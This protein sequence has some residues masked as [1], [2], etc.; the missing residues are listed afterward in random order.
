MVNLNNIIK[1]NNVKGSV[2][3]YNLRDENTQLYNTVGSFTTDRYADFK[4]NIKSVY[5]SFANEYN[6]NI[7]DEISNIAKADNLREVYKNRLLGDVMESA[8]EDP[9]FATMP[10]K[11]EQLFE[12]TMFEIA[13]ESSAMMLYPAIGLTLPILKKNYIEGHSKDI[14]MTEVATKPVVRVAFERK[15]LKDKEGNKYY[16]PEIYYDNSYK[17]VL[18]KGQ[19]DP[20]YSDW[21]PELAGVLPMQDYDLLGKSGGSIE[22]RDRFDYNLAITAVQM[23]VDDGLGG[24]ETVTVEGLDIRPDPQA[25]SNMP[26]HNTI[27]YRVSCKNTALTKFEDIVVFI[28][29]QYKGLVSVSSTAGLVKKVKFGGKLSN[30]NN[31]NGLEL[32]REREQRQWSI[33]EKTRFNTGLTVEKIKDYKV[34]L[35]IDITTEYITDISTNLTQAEDSDILDFLRTS[36]DRWT[37]IGT[38]NLPF[39][40]DQKFTE[41]ASF[42]CIPPVGV[43]IVPSMWIANE[44][45]YNINRLIDRLKVKLRNADIMFV[46]YGHPNN[47]TLL[48]DDVKW[49]IDEDTKIGGVQLDYR[50][51]VWTTNKSRV[52]VVSTLK[53]PAENGLRLVLYP[54]TKEMI[55]FKHFKYS[56]NIENIYRNANTPLTPNIM[57][58]SRYETIELLPI[59]GKMNITDNEFGIL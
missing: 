20:V 12:N 51:G 10:A 13:K 9:Y 21:L 42:S 33:S 26:Q 2:N 6:M 46:M 5:E 59:Q 18:S 52:H 16:I 23:D 4:N 3:M 36:F 37:A 40:Y 34:L 29:D 14:V 43:P 24:T 49:V 17:A 30:E 55:T 22:K 15:F 11:L 57:G 32:D 48:Q 35:D 27:S 7:F 25:L 31:Y 28:V 53:E 39:G 56:I 38:G 54:L 47:I 1:N 58:T 44:L 50:F 19:G 41:T 8:I 45:K